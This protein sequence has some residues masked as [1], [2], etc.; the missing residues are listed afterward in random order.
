MY[1][2]KENKELFRDAVLLASQK[3]EVSE[4]IVEKDYYVTM[5]LKKLYLKVDLHF[6][7]HFRLLIVSLR[8]LISRLQST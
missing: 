3:L 6:Q 4:D 5:I 1:L 8:I 2:H 7:K